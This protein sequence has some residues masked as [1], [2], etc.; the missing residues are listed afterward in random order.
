MPMLDHEDGKKVWLSDDDLSSI[1]NAL[2]TIAS[3]CE[4]DAKAM[5]QDHPSLSKALTESAQGYRK[6]LT[7]LQGGES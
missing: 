3:L 6:V 2:S 7:K 5:A 1:Q 4:K